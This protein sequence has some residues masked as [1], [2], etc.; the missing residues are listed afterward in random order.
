MRS[1]RTP[2]SAE[3]PRTPRGVSIH[4]LGVAAQALLKYCTARSCFRAAARD[5]NV[6][7]FLRFPVFASF[8]RE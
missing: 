7:R 4:A 3:L 8:F 1:R 6:P 2:S 5:E